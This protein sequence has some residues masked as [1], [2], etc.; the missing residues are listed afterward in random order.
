MITCILKKH[1]SPFWQA[2]SVENYCFKAFLINVETF[3][4]MLQPRLRNNRGT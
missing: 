2:F 4:L 3:F 1:P